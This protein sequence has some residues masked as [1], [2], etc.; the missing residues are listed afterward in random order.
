MGRTEGDEVE[1][2]TPAGKR[3]FEIVKLRTIHDSEE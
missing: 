2:T 1:I 3:R